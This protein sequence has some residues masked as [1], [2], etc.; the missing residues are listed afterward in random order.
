MDADVPL[1]VDCLYP[2]ASSI[3]GLQVTVID[4]SSDA[5]GT[6]PC[7]ALVGDATGSIEAR[8]VDAAQGWDTLSPGAQIVVEEGGVAVDE[9]GAPYIFVSA[10][11]RHADDGDDGGGDDDDVDVDDVD[12][13][14]DI[15]N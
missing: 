8:A 4:C 11:R 6:P 13:V 1:Y 12:D 9:A 10:V 2:S 15:R 14:D 3:T 5:P 7:R